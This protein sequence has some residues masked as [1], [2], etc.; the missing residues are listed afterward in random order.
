[1]QIEV[2]KMENLRKL[3][4]EKGLSAKAL[5]EMV[6]KAEVTITQYEKGNRNPPKDTLALLADILETSTDYLLGK[7]KDPVQ[8]MDGIDKRIWEMITALSPQKKK[9]LLQYLAGLSATPED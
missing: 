2:V 1:M 3:R 4:K 9:Y 6:G 5:G 7:E 8:E